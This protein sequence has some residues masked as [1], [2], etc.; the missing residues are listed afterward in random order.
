MITDRFIEL[1]TK[2]LSNEITPDEYEELKYLL[3]ADEACKQQYEFFKS[4][5]EENKKQEENTDLLFLKIKNRLNIEDQPDNVI[6]RT[7]FFTFW[8]SIAAVLLVGICL[9]IGYKYF[10]EAGAGNSA[11]AKLEQTQTARRNKSKITLSD[12]SVVTLN[13]ET[14][15]KYPSAFNGKTREVYL[16]GEAFFEVAK[17]HKHPFIVHA[18]KMSIKVLGTAFNVKSYA[19]DL[20][21]E[22]TLIRGVIEVTLADRPSDRIILKPNEKL[23]LQNNGM[24]DIHRQVKRNVPSPQDSVNAKY[25]LT[26]L[27]YLKSNDS[28]IVET[29][30]VNNKLVFKDE[31]FGQLSNQMERWYGVNIK[32]KNDELKE[33]RFTG[34]FEKETIFQALSALQ[35]IEPFRYK[36]KNGLIYIY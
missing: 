24:A 14:V 13:A 10:S 34:V 7:S 4:Y 33:Y 31:D 2:K 35:R 22:T 11:L 25:A 16:S 8:R 17:D 23:V 12:G 6:R 1:L 30:W 3:G 15:L 32:F 28:T 9:Y 29:S 27:T 26:N 19:N 36:F 21:S 20:A 5:W 18:D